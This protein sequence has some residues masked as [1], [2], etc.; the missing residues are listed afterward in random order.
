MAAGRQYIRVLAGNVDRSSKHSHFLE[1]F[2]TLISWEAI[3]YSVIRGRH[4][5]GIFNCGWRGWGADREDIYIMFDFKT[6]L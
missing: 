1:V 4:A 6:V 5:P 2:L 3:S